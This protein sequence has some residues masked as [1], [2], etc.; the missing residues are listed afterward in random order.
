MVKSKPLATRKPLPFNLVKSKPA[1][2]Y[3]SVTEAWIM[4]NRKEL[5][6]TL[7]IYLSKRFPLSRDRDMIEDHVQSFICDLLAKDTL[8]T[9]DEIKMSG[10]C[11]LAKHFVFN[12]IRKN[13][14]DPDYK[15]QYGGLTESERKDLAN[16][17]LSE[18]EYIAK[19]NG[20]LI[21][22]LEQNQEKPMS[23]DDLAIF[24]EHV[25]LFEAHLVNSVSHKKRDLALKVYDLMQQGY[26]N[27]QIADELG[28]ETPVIVNKLVAVIKQELVVFNESYA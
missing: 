15:L 3:S 14:R 10:V 23:P 7:T 19:R 9:Q 28:F 12:D 20:D 4:E 22:A 2:K 6:K 18:Q 8:S 5:Y 13:S 17:K 11:Y 16:T 26:K 25:S 1:P 27:I 21:G 24:M